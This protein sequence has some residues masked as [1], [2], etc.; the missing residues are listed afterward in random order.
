MSGPS[1]PLLIG[2]HQGLP[3]FLN[4]SP[5]VRLISR[6]VAASQSTAPAEQMAA[7]G[8]Q[9]WVTIDER[10]NGTILNGPLRPTHPSL[11]HANTRSP[12]PPPEVKLSMPH[13]NHA[14]NKH[15]IQSQALADSWSREQAEAHRISQMVS[16]KLFCSLKRRGE[17]GEK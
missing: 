3:C 7:V 1:A 13:S 12:S 10:G 17:K 15:S 16:F 8:E 9:K 5:Q 6:R 14:H 2:R 11:P 4:G